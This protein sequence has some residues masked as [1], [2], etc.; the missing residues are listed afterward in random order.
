MKAYIKE[1]F[2]VSFSG[3][4]LVAVGTVGLSLIALAD[5]FS[6]LKEFLQR[7][8]STSSYTF[9]YFGLVFNLWTSS[10]FIHVISLNILLS[11][12]SLPSLILF[13]LLLGASGLIGYFVGIKKGIPSVLLLFVL[14][15]I[16][17]LVLAIITPATIPTA[18]LSPEDQQVVQG[19]GEEFFK[20]TYF[21]T[22]QSSC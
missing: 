16:F 5:P 22:S 6:A 7:Y 4:V 3:W 20:L 13:L 11:P 15:T 12:L 19:L 9:E 14:S 1:T 8:G 18:G 21:N 10:T 17:G 2:I